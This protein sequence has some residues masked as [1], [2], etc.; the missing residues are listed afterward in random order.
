MV[1][2]CL[3]LL[4]KPKKSLRTF[5]NIPKKTVTYLS[6]NNYRIFN[7]KIKIKIIN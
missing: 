4:I 7:S 5:N 2:N 3:V 1:Y 6:N